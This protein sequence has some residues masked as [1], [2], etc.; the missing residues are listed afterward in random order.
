MIDL[1]SVSQN[2]LRFLRSIKETGPDGGQK[3]L[4]E[5]VDE[6]KRKLVTASDMVL[7]HRLQG[8]AEAYE[9]LLRA[10]DESAKAINRT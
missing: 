8:R 1:N 5:L 3:F 7:I 2:N 6:A 4:A 9:D 10:I